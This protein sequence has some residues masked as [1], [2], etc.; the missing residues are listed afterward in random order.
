M[1][2]SI[3]EKYVEIVLLFCYWSAIYFSAIC[4]FDFL[5]FFPIG[6]WGNISYYCSVALKWIIKSFYDRYL[7][8]SKWK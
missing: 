3:D 2:K 1:V 6:F 7:C 4:I 8:G 5:Y